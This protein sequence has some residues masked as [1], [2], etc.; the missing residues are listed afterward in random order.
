MTVDEIAHYGVKGMK[1]GVRKEYV[2]HPRNPS[3][4]KAN[5]QEAAQMKQ[6]LKGRG[7]DVIGSIYKGKSKAW[8]ASRI[9]AAPVTGWSMAKTA[10][11]LIN[12][13][14]REKRATNL[15]A[16]TQ[17][18][19]ITSTPDE[20]LQRIYAT[21]NEYDNRMYRGRLGVLQMKQNS[22]DTYVKTFTAKAGVK[23]PSDDKARSMFQ[24]L[25]DSDK[26][27]KN[28]VDHMP[29]IVRGYV[30]DAKTTKDR[31][32]N[33]NLQGLMDHDPKNAKQVQKYYDLLS[34]N[35]Y[36]AITDLNDRYY[37]T[38]EANNPI[39]IFDMQN[40]VETNIRKL[41]AKEVRS[42]L[43]YDAKVRVGR[44]AANKWL[45]I[46]TSD[47]NARYFYDKKKQVS[48]SEDLCHYGV[49]ED[50]VK[51]LMVIGGIG[52]AAY[53]GKQVSTTRDRKKKKRNE[54]VNVA[55]ELYHYGVKGMR[56]G[57]RKTRESN[58]RREAKKSFT[59]NRKQL[60]RDRYQDMASMTDAELQARINRLQK[61]QQ[62]QQLTATSAQK[63][64]KKV[65]DSV[66]IGAAI[67]V[68]SNRVQKSMNSAIDKG[69]DSVAKSLSRLAN[70]RRLRGLGFA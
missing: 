32:K 31:Y 69:A 41:S 4:K 1:W 7:G 19:R 30:K 58:P 2:P 50:A 46:A 25:Y 54:V 33:F 13:V 48:H 40:L 21:Y 26:D 42:D 35:G 22:G 5:N 18:Q 6:F 12:D 57:I 70:A 24:S 60:S 59:R 20:K 67:T 47:E 8:V 53:A 37:S 14:Y 9:A 44:A 15:K 65:V 3:K 51:G 68:A 38:F 56:W 39:I 61:E 52:G 64:G 66:L 55:G 49:K 45:G 17:F 43:A 28:Y 11:K 62:Y 36:N 29:Q 16:G 63:I 10:P 34:K 23:A 27:F